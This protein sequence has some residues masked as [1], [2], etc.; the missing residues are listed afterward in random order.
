MR[1]EGCQ[2]H[3]CR[4]GKCGYVDGMVG[5]SARGVQPHHAV[6]DRALVDHLADRG[7]LVAE[8]GDGKRAFRGFLGREEAELVHVSYLLFRRRGTF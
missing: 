3:A 2:L 1:D 5:R 4:T 7:K 8:R 6:D